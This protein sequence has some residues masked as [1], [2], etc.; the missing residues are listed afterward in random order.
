MEYGQLTSSTQFCRELFYHL[1]QNRLSLGP[2]NIYILLQCPSVNA[3]DLGIINQILNH[4]PCT[5]VIIS[6]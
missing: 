1:R 4:L 3:L 5:G 6:H 2:L